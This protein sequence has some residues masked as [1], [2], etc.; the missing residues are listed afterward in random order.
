[1]A[2]ANPFS[3]ACLEVMRWLVLLWWGPWAED[4]S[5]KP[6]EPWAMLN[7]SDDG[8]NELVDHFSVL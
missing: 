7:L 8:Q 6:S 3:Q 4:P 2:H 1:M 5:C